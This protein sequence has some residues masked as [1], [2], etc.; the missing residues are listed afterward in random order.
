MI[1]NK[2]LDPIGVS[3][4][5]IKKYYF[6]TLSNKLTCWVFFSF[7]FFYIKYFFLSNP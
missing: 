2:F 6:K 3:I 4:F 7:E 1:E 5:I